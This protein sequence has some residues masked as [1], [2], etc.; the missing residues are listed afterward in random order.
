MI[1]R[2]FWGPYSP[3][4]LIVAGLVALADQGNKLWMLYVYDIGSKQP[5]AVT[6]FFDL[7]LP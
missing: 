4:G 7:D 6:P 3:L 5:V 1:R 2:W